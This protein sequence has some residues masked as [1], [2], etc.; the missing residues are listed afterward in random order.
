MTFCSQTLVTRS[1]AACLV[2]NVLFFACVARTAV[3]P[4]SRDLQ[5]CVFRPEWWSEFRSS[6]SVAVRRR[7]GVVEGILPVV[8]VAAQGLEIAMRRQGL[9]C[10]DMMGGR[11]RGWLREGLVAKVELALVVVGS[12]GQV[13]EAGEQVRFAMHEFM[14]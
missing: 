2:L 14:Q 1:T 13:M 6:H 3:Y 4:I 9:S 10:G 8:L 12:L 11:R 7:V 5:N